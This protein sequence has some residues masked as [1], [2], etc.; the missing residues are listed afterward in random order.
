MSLK[1]FKWSQRPTPRIKFNIQIIT[2]KYEIRKQRQKKREAIRFP[3]LIVFTYSISHTKP[4]GNVTFVCVVVLLS[5]LPAGSSASTMERLC[6]KRMFVHNIYCLTAK[7]TDAKKSVFVLSLFRF[8]GGGLDEKDGR[9]VQR[10]LRG[11]GD[12]SVFVRGGDLPLVIFANSL[13]N[14]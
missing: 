2:Q 8:A 11:K 5:K 12:A 14:G 7:N 13:C 9:L 10:Y 6:P 3:A 1:I 4:F